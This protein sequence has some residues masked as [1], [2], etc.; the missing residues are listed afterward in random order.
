VA[1]SAS[2]TRPATERVGPFAAFESP[3]YPFF[4]LSSVAASMGVQT[5]TVIGQWQVYALTHSPFQL[6]LVGLMNVLPIILFGVFGGAYADMAD[7]RKLVALSQ[8]V[9]I[10]V[11]GALGL[12]TVSG[13]IEVWHVYV[14]G[15]IG[16]FATAFDQPSR[17]AM[18]FSL[19]PRRHLLNAVTWHNVQRDT[20]N[21]VGPAAAGI[22][23]AAVSIGAAY[24]A[25]ALLFVPLII[26]MIRLRVG[27]A[28]PARPSA[29]GLLRDGLQFV[30]QSPVIV[31]SLALDFCLSFF[32]AYRG[33]L[34]LYAR[35]ILRVGPEGFGFLTS[36]VAVGGILGSSIVLSL[37]E[38]K[39]KGRIQIGAML[40]YAGGVGAFGLST[41]FPLSL[42]LAGVLGCCDTVAGTMRRSIVQLATPEE[43]QGRVGALQLIVAQS[44]PALGSAQ[45]GT[46]SGM[47]GGPAALSIG[48]VVCGTAALAAAMRSRAFREV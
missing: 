46:M 27:G 34:A 45:A 8:V 10:G 41:L 43:M 26:A 16:S 48:A 29:A 36:A 23:M 14:G 47:I 25:N 3:G 33:I 39:H 5:Q 7:R 44:G 4:W 21:L 37:G 2:E 1:E 35:D 19:V 20:S 6:G 9:R 32:G 13:A 40:V 12:L 15:L 17:Q 30:G 22:I 18:I 42:A 11:V 31:T 38:S 28:P 24:F